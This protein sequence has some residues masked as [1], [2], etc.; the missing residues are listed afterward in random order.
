MTRGSVEVTHAGHVIPLQA[1]VQSP[2]V[3]PDEWCGLNEV[4]DSDGSAWHPWHR[5]E[6]KEPIHTIPRL[7][8]NPP[9]PQTF[10]CV[11]RREAHDGAM[12]RTN[13][14]HSLCHLRSCRSFHL[15]FSGATSERLVNVSGLVCPHHVGITPHSNNELENLM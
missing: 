4:K 6:F 15:S 12:A 5:H 2:M 3:Q 11:V 8:L 7:T 13:G 1:Y 9:I 10:I 14:G